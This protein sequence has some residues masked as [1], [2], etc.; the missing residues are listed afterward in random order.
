MTSWPRLDLRSSTA[1]IIES[2]QPEGIE[3]RDMQELERIKAKG[4]CELVPN[5]EGPINS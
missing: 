4:V 3:D 2:H 5:V 1:A